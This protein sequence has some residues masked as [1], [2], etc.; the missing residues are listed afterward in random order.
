MAKDPA[1]LFY[2]KDFQ[3]GT[4]DMSCA[5]VGAYLRLLMYQHQHGSIPFDFQKLRR[6]T[7]CDSLSEMQELFRAMEGKFELIEENNVKHL[8]NRKLNHVVNQRTEFRPK[9]IASAILAGLISS[10][11][12]LNDLQRKEIKKQFKIDDFINFSDLEMKEK[13]R[14]WFNDLV[15][16]MVNNIVNANAIVNGNVIV[17]GKGGVGEKP[18]EQP[19]MYTVGTQTIYGPISAFFENNY[20]MAMEAGLMNNL[21]EKS[22]A[23]QLLDNEYPPGYHFRDGNH[24]IKSFSYAIQRKQCKEPISKKLELQDF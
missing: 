5:E 9:K 20:Q 19:V 23:L 2:T 13:I 14:F 3:S 12:Q 4:Q 17:N 15:N 7:G 18:K 1:F 16:H 6:I 8:V 10:N 21:M 22:E 24:L 11:T